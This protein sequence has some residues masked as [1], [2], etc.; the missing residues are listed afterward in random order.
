[1][2]AKRYELLCYSCYS[3]TTKYSGIV[4]FARI[5]TNANEFFLPCDTSVQ[6]DFSFNISLDTTYR[7]HL[8]KIDLSYKYFYNK[9]HTRKIYFLTYTHDVTYAFPIACTHD[10]T[11]FFLFC[12]FAAMH[13]VSSLLRGCFWKRRHG[14]ANDLDLGTTTTNPCVE[15]KEF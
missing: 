6:H 3:S 15:S 14:V 13:Y 4:K 5:K 11:I 7:K 10:V 1:M 8:Q 12:F 9:F 2:A